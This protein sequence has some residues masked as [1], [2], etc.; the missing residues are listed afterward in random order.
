M[1]GGILRRR[2]SRENEDLRTYA[3]Y[4]DD[5]ATGFD[6]LKEPRGS[7]IFIL[8]SFHDQRLPCD[9]P[10]QDGI[11]VP[12]DATATELSGGSALLYDGVRAAIDQW[13]F[14][15]AIVQGDAQCEE[16]NFGWSSNSPNGQLQ[17]RS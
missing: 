4:S 15:P 3:L 8:R 1:F 6:P 11:S 5:S 17:A 9:R 10:C 7:S 14:S 13:K 12:S 16:R 2:H